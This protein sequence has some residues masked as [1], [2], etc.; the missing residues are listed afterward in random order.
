MAVKTDRESTRKQSIMPSFFST[1]WCQL[2]IR[3]IRSLVQN[4]SGDIF[5]FIYFFKWDYSSV[6]RVLQRPCGLPKLDVFTRRIY[7]ML[8]ALPVVQVTVWTHW[9]SYVNSYW[10]SVCLFQTVRVGPVSCTCA[11]V[12][13]VQ[14]K[15]LLK[16]NVQCSWSFFLLNDTLI[17][18]V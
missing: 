8:D 13:Y 14:I 1:K 3:V 6:G 11:C 2:V 5:K 16:T 17:T 12:Y 10:S 9:T 18:F 15:R 4:V 7:Y